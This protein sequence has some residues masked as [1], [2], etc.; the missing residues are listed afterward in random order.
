MKIDAKVRSIAKLKDY[1]FLVPDYQREYVWQPD[2]Q[3][4]QFL[5]D[6]ENEYVP[7]ANVPR[8][9]FLGSI[10]IVSNGDRFD[11][12]DGQQRLTTI[13]LALCAFRDLL[14]DSE[15]DEVQNKYLQEI[16]KLLSDFDIE[17]GETR[18][19]LELQYEESH[20]YL[21]TLIRKL[22]YFGE[23]TP[24]I[25][26]MKKA[27]ER[28]V[29]NF[30]QYDPLDKLTDFIRYFLTKIE[31]VVIESQ[32]LSSALKIFE[33]IN[34]RGAGLN[35]MDLVKNLL[36]SHTKEADFARIKEIWRGIISNLQ[37]CLEDQ[38]PLRFL[39]YFL[40]ARYCNGNIR[41]D[42]I[43]KWIISADGKRATQYEDH[44]VEF[45]NEI[46]CISKRYA[47]LVKATELQQDGGDYPHVT[48]IGFINKYKSRQHLILLL[49]LGR[50]A[51]REAIEYLARQIESF[52][53]YSATLR[54]QA[55]NNETLFVQWAE[56]LRGLTEIREIAS[57]IEATMLPYLIG[58]VRDFKA[59]FVDLAQW[60]YNPLYRLRYVLGSIERRISVRSDLPQPGHNVCNNLQIEHVLP[61]TPK[62]SVIPSEFASQDEYYSYVYRL[63]NITLLEGTINEALNNCNDLSG[64]E[65]FR[66]KQAEYKKSSVWLTKMLDHEYSIGIDTALNRFKNDSGYVFENW[67]KAAIEKR[68]RILL[69]LVFDTWRINDRRLDKVKESCDP[70]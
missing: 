6:I 53:F 12:V 50:N 13:M 39:R 58:I 60:V 70:S 3:V 8:S 63:G 47:E 61:Q 41:E 27:Y 24:S 7:F 49:S 28:I 42:D 11:V 26:R 37:G 23:C 21:T 51:T 29:Q 34:Q 36:F 48:N 19:R 16:D 25:L 4:E 64:D 5:T 10:I 17:S 43:Y 57:V 2:D 33:T 68:Q 46:L 67:N 9:Y 38:S 31:I 59:E 62:D 1:F 30:K 65:W 20:D 56:K 15:R 55:K 69:D 40:I 32:D 45:A 54:I 14:D 44:P 52:F 66:C 18:V 22:D 35:A